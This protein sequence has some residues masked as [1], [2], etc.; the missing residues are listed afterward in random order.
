MI[1]EGKNSVKEA[2]LANKTIEKLFIQKGYTDK[3]MQSV[4]DLA[5]SNGIRIT[6][7]DKNKLDKLTNNKHQGIVANISD[8]KYCTIE[9]I[10][11][12]AKDKNEK[13]NI[14]ILDGIEDPHNFGS[15]IRSALVSGVHG[16]IVPTVRASSITSTVIR[17]S[18][19]AVHHLKIAKVTNINDA[20]RKLKDNFINIYSADMNGKCMY[21][22]NL[23]DDIAVVIGNEGKGVKALTK[24]LSDDIISIPMK[25]KLDSLNASVA[26]GIIM[27]E[28]LR[29]RY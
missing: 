23:T 25:G 2:L 3:Q 27:Y 9:D 5:K 24:K 18:A 6:F 8:I 12:F 11:E 20:I 19:G 15:I 14:I 13:V 28:I 7:C 1:I 17:S 21:D 29:Q 16:I 22:I 10:L 4:I 26:S